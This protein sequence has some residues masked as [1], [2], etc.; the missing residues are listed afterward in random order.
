MKTFLVFLL[1][2]GLGAFGYY[3]YL[4]QPQSSRVTALPSAADTGHQIADSARS[5]AH[6]AAAET[7]EVATN[8]SDAVN[9]KL[10]QWHLT[11]ADIKADLARTGQVVRDNTARAGE[12]IAD[13]R[14]VTVIKAKY[15]LDRVL[16]ATA[17]EV[18]SHDGNVTLIGTVASEN[19]VAKAVEQ[20]LDTEGVHHVVAKLSI[21]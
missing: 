6:S 12:R 17:I 19:L 16:S 15:V 7:H 2:L 4:A 3:L 20:A 1:G 13:A 14:I 9:E 18:D 11:G 10:V 8:V 5:A 21:R